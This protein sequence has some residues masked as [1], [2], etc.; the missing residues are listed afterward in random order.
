M[1]GTAIEFD[2]VSVRFG[3]LIALDRVSVSIPAGAFVALVGP[4]GGGKTTL[5]HLAAG[6]RRPDGGKVRVLGEVPGAVDAMKVGYVPQAKRLDPQVPAQAIELVATGLKP[7]WPWSLGADESTALE[8]MR[9]AGIEHRARHRVGTLSG[10]EL[11]RVYLARA[12]ARRP[13]VL[14]LDE[15]AAGIDLVGEAE[16]YHTLLHYQQDSGCTILMI[17]HDWEGARAHASHALLLNRSVRAFGPAKE[18]ANEE[19]LL[20]LFGHTGH[21]EATHDHA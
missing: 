17:T 9:A 18:T 6:L 11:Q 8:A 2:S 13:E 4:N 21:I 15:P 3:D 19:R 14:L 16:M 20:S 10:G 7:R 5:L 12:L 1:S